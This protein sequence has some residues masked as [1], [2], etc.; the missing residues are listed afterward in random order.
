M[1][2]YKQRMIEEYKQLKKRA[3]KLSIVLNRYYLDELDFELSC[4]IELL[5]T[6]RCCIWLAI[7]VIRLSV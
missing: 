7:I 4:P 1:E 6:Q 3:E 2:I 5:Q